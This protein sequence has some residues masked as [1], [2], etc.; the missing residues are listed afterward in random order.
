MVTRATPS[1]FDSNISIQLLV[2][3]LRDRLQ[4]E[5]AAGA[6]DDEVEPLDR[7]G[8]LVDR[9]LVGDVERAAARPPTSAASASQRSSRRAAAIVS[10]PAAASARTRRRADPARGPGDQR[11]GPS[12][13]P[14]RL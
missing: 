3:E 7:R 11:D 6:V 14:A 5:G 8:Q 10:N 4:P 1:T 2:V 12:L 9:R 13:T